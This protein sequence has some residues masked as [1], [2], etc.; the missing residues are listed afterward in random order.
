METTRVEYY[1]EEVQEGKFRI[2]QRLLK[3]KDTA[4]E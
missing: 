2:R 3:N 4:L 1:H